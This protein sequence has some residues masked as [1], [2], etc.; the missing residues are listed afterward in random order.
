MEGR[1][2]VSSKYQGRN[3]ARPSS[4][5]APRVLCAKILNRPGSKQSNRTHMKTKTALS[6]LAAASLAL[7]SA[8]FAAGGKTYQVT[9]PVLE[10]N[11]SM[12]AV[13]KGKDRWEIN[14]D[15]STKVSGDL[16]VGEKVTITYTM[17]AT[18]VEVKAAKGAKKEAASPAASPKK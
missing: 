9:G 14:R 11:D 16:K 6:L 15:S 7:S 5:C 18:D 2:S 17:S 13:Q 12:I 8:A 10:V 1:P 3:G 4:L